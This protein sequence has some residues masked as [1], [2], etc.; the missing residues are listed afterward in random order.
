LEFVT[1]QSGTSKEHS[2]RDDEILEENKDE[3]M[4]SS[5]I[6]KSD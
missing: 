2:H 5:P 6:E 3:N 1:D 4:L